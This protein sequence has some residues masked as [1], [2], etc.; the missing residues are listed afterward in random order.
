[1]PA[2]KASRPALICLLAS[3]ACEYRQNISC[4]RKPCGYEK[5][6]PAEHLYRFFGD[7]QRGGGVTIGE[8]Q[9]IHNCKV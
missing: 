5:M 9:L 1:M 4:D 3:K 2:I 7:L 8:M 6:F